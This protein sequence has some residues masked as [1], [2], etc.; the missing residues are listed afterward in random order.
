MAFSH[1]SGGRGSLLEIQEL[2]VAYDEVRVIQELNLEL[3]PGEVLG[4]IGPNGAGK[5]TLIRAVSGVLEVKSGSI[6]SYGEDLL[7]LEPRER[8]RR[9]A[10]VPQA[11]QLGGALTVEQTVLMGRTAYMGFLGR[12]AAQDRDAVWKAMQKTSVD[13]M[14]NRRNSELSSGEQQRVLLA[15][16]LAQDTPILLLDEPT[17]HLDISHQA[18]FLTLVREMAEKSSLGIL[19]AFH[20]LNLVSA[21]THRIALLVEGEIKAIGSPTEVLTAANIQSAYNTP[22]RILSHPD[23]DTPMVL[24]AWRP[25]PDDE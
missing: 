12:P 9:L 23:L 20:D 2:N 11:R 25:W 17:S 6:L 8:A 19:I 3:A 24:P 10:V 5:S 13:H 4:L 14:A 18:G 21:F 7:S 1:Q 16:A 15:R 22:V